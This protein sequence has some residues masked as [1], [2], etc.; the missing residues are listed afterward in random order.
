M[1]KFSD[2]V[3]TDRGGIVENRHVVH[4]AVTDVSGN[5]LRA[6]GDPRR[7]TLARSAAKPAQAL[8]VMETGAFE[9]FGFDDEDLALMCASHSSEDRHI[10]RA[11]SM[12]DKSG[13]EAELLQC[14]GHVPLSDKVY[15]TWIKNDFEPGGLCNNCSGKHAGMMAGCKSLG[16]PVHDYHSMSSPMQQ[17]VMQAVEDL[18]GPD[19]GPHGVQWA[20][21]GCNLPAP[22]F[23]LQCMATTYARFAD[24]ADTASD[25]SPERTRYMA[26]IF[27]AMARFPEMV[28]G[29]GRF[30]TELMQAYGGS[31]VGKL[32]ADGCYGVAVRESDQTR[33]L[34]A[35]GAIGISVKIEDGSIEILYAAVAEILAQLG[36]GSPSTTQ[37]LEAF[38]HL[39]RRNTMNVKTG[40]VTLAFTVRR[41][42]AE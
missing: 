34:G 7:I 15:K 12:L 11:Q 40:V 14:G 20:I 1:T 23:P 32:G 8:A 10:M 37:A 33:K 41:T 4:A 18:V 27:H 22:A 13:A 35:T 36:I 30:C 9:Q 42:D 28:G 29:E 39:K 6:V 21:D 3:V 2:S 26:R 5:L 16:A 24:A 25:S 17:R 38:H 31:L 19:I